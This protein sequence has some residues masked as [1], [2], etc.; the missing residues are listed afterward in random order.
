MPALRIAIIGSAD[1]KRV[2]EL[3]L[4]YVEL[5]KEAGEYLGQALASH[6]CHIIVYD[7][8]EHFL[9]ADVVRG[10]ASVKNVS[11]QSI[12]ICFPQ[13]GVRPSFTEETENSSLFKPVAKIGDNWKMAFYRSLSEADGAIVLG[14]GIST[15]IS[16]ISLIGF[17]KPVIACAAFGG[18]GQRLWEVLTAQP[19][20]IQEEIQVMAEE[21]W[22]LA[23]AERLVKILIDQDGRIK[24]KKEEEIQNIISEHVKD[25]NN[26]DR[27]ALI[28]VILLVVGALAWPLAWGVDQVNLFWLII[29]LIG[30]SL[31]AGA[32]G[33]TIRV[34]FDRTQGVENTERPIGWN[35]ALGLTG[36]VVSAMLFILAQL[37]A[38]PSDMNNVAQIAQV[39]RLVP[40]ATIIGFIAGL[41]LEVVFLRLRETSIVN[42]TAIKAPDQKDV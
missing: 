30:T 1:P 17:N 32:A 20:V 19:Y 40:F 28:S 21:K 2:T 39:K 11:P 36:G 22:S 27:H 15:L 35:I 3:D 41:T 34:V 24:K 8:R 4:K 26:I 38:T 23:T 13:R 18:S 33:A 25:K 16:G 6:G 42:V 31:L 29:L 9:E 10:Y 37:V 5:A 14:G 12:E 7:N